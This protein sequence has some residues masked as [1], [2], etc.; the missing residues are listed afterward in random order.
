MYEKRT[1][2][3]SITQ[4]PWQIFSRAYS[5][6]FVADIPEIHIEILIGKDNPRNPQISTTI[7]SGYVKRHPRFKKYASPDYSLDLR[8]DDLLE[9]INS[10]IPEKSYYDVAVEK[11]SKALGVN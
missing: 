9:E 5:T 3:T 8:L 4:L 11:V 10:I 7:H 2:Y 1:P 6:N